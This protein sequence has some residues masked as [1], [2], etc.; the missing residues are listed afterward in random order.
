MNVKNTLTAIT[1]VAIVIMLVSLFVVAL[2]PKHEFHETTYIVVTGDCLWDIASK[3]CPKSMDKW[4]YIY[5]VYDANNLSSYTL[6]PG[7][8]LT[9]YEED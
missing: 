5:L 7:Q 1:M 8:V 9:V 2:A 6:Q 4:D 3:Y